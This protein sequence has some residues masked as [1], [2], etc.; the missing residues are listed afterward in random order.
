MWTLVIGLFDKAL[1]YFV[2][3][4]EI[5]AKKVEMKNELALAKI[6]RDKAQAMANLN[7]TSDYDNQAMKNMQSSFKDEYIILLHT[8]PVYGYLIPSPT[9]YAA[10]DRVWFQL[11]NA[12]YEWWVIYIG[13][14]ASTFGLRW[15]LSKDKINKILTK[16]ESGNITQILEAN[17][18]IDDMQHSID[19]LTQEINKLKQNKEE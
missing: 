1:G 9:M 3:T 16:A 5:K 10:L 11:A 19:L 7:A 15:F 6:D 17:K 14:V 13:I 8:L 18:K 2:D 12:P 4:P